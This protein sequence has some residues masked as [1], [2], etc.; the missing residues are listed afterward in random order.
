[1]GERKKEKEKKKKE[2]EK[3]D[4]GNPARVPT[5]S[6]IRP[7]S[8]GILISRGQKESRETDREFLWINEILLRVQPAS[9][10]ASNGM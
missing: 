8:A 1:M 4:R 10:P 7:P 5:L 3:F 6:I 2:K 9:L